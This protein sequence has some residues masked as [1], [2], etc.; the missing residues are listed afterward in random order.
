M[1]ASEEAETAWRQS[2][3]VEL[4][5]PPSAKARR[6]ALAPPAL[7]LMQQGV[8]E[9]ERLPY[10][11]LYLLEHG[12]YVHQRPC[13]CLSEPPSPNAP[14]W[15]AF[16][17]EGKSCWAGQSDEQLGTSTAFLQLLDASMPETPDRAASPWQGAAWQDALSPSDGGWTPRLSLRCTALTYEQCEV[18]GHGD[19]GG[20][21]RG[22]G[23]WCVHVRAS[24]T[25][26]LSA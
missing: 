1:V 18:R 22:H 4:P 16:V 8:L 7:L 24:T 15:L 6:L 14:R 10:E 9:G 23:W 12:S 19:R 25:V 17:T 2:D 13:F 5:I 3:G 21:G 20:G 11:G 26:D